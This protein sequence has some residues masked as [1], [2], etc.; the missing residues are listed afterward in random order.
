MKTADSQ[1]VAP[2]GGIG[3]SSDKDK[4]P[5]ALPGT[6]FKAVTAT[7]SYE[8]VVRQVETAIR[9]GK[10]DRGQRL[11]TERQLSEAFSV[12]RGVIREAVKVLEAMGLVEARQGSGIY[13]RNDTIPSVTRAFILSVSPDA[14]SLDR[15]FEF[16]RGI[17][18]E[19][20]RFAAIRHGEE[21]IADMERALL[22][23]EQA[24]DPLDWTTFR[25]NDSRF[26]DAITRA[27]GNPYLGVAIAT[28][29]DM[30]RDVVNLIAAEAGSIRTAIMQHREIF[31]A[32][33]TGNPDLAGQMMASHVTYTADAVQSA[34]AWEARHDT[35]SIAG[36][37]SG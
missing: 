28:T 35:E 24:L 17:E 34:I 30:Q 6:I 5:A 33:R 25:E 36:K 21:H 19:A 20:A 26:H 32:I 18:A 8:A 1:P 31:E 23:I 9:S 2:Q 16:R 13:V 29:H 4:P 14:E 22:A 3:A 10:I 12:S 11:P 37:E 7:R 15:L 27:S